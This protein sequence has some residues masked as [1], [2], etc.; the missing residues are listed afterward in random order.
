MSNSPPTVR[1]RI[2][3]RPPIL[4][5]AAAEDPVPVQAAENAETWKLSRSARGLFTEGH[6]WE[7]WTWRRMAME[8][9]RK[10]AKQR[11]QESQA[12]Q[13][14]GSGNSAT[15]EHYQ[16]DACLKQE[17]P[18]WFQSL[19]L[20]ESPVTLCQACVLNFIQQQLFYPAG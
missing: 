11:H 19:T 14:T 15:T 7:N 1:D 12:S 3:F 16:C 18:Q 10:A 13:S 9:Q 20:T 4:P 17:T 6:R 2:D 8:K 5:S